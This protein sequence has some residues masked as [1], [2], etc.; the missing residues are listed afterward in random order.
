VAVHHLLGVHHR[1]D[2]VQREAGAAQ[3]ADE[4]AG[5]GHARRLDDH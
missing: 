4:R 1:D 5:V 3:L 2:R